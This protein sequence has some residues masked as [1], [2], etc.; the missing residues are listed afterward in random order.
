MGFLITTKLFDIVGSHRAV[1]TKRANR[2]ASVLCQYCVCV[3]V[4]VCVCKGIRYSFPQI[5]SKP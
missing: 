2:C 5:I 4:C 1:L 3:C